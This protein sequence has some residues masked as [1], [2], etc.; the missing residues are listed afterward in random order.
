MGAKNEP[1]PSFPSRRV[2]ARTRDMIRRLL[3]ALALLLGFIVAPPAQADEVGNAARGVVRIVTI[4]TD[5]DQV[6]AFGHGSGFAVAPNRV[7][8]NAHV[9]QLAQQYP[10]NVVIGVVPPSGQRGFEGRVIAVDQQHDLALIEFRGDP[11]PPVALFS[12]LLGGGQGVAALGYPGNVDL[13]T[14]RS[15][16]DYTVPVAPIRSEGSF[17]GT[18]VLNGTTMLLHTANIARGNSGG[19]LLDRCGRV[20][21]VNS[22]ITRNEEGDSTFAFA[23]AERELAAFLQAANQPFTAVATPCQGLA[24]Q[25]RAAEAEADAARD[26]A[27]EIAARSHGGTD[28]GAAITAAAV[29][30]ENLLGLGMLI[31]LV[32]G[33]AVSSAVAFGVAGRRGGAAVLAIVGVLLMLGGVALFVLRPGGG[34]IG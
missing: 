14:A 12:G 11:L 1:Q 28:N 16:N 18:R 34:I 6:V 23:I 7:V 24:D 17:G 30:R 31:A 25:E 20:V 33:I 32:G 29:R 15:I 26:R 21:G 19:P 4:A 3:A 22:A 27:L 8:T 10:G 2:A 13:A 9:V 5:G